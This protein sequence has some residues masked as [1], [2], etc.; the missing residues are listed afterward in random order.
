MVPAG[1]AGSQ[2]PFWEGKFDKAGYTYRLI[3]TKTQDITKDEIQQVLSTMVE[4]RGE[5]AGEGTQESTEP[6]EPELTAPLGDNFVGDAEEAAEEYYQAAGLEDWEFTYEHLDSETQNLFTEEEWIKKNQYYWDQ[7][8]TTYNILSV[9][10]LPDPE[11]IITEVEVRITGED[12]SSFDRTTYWVLE[13]EWLHR[14]S[15]EEI[16]LFMPDLS[17]EE[18]VE[19]NQ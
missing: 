3:V 1:R 2:G 5:V 11:E 18:F 9:E 7:S 19:A 8:E 14:F 6:T 12:G 13:D 4:V 10:Q 16:D 15:Q 17:Y